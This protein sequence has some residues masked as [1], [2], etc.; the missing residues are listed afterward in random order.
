MAFANNE[1]AFNFALQ[2]LR[3][4]FRFYVERYERW[5]AE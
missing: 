3:M 4:N 1:D 5:R 2:D